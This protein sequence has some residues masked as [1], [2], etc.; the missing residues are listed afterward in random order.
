MTVLR[1]RTIVI[2][3]WRSRESPVA[4]AEIARAGLMRRSMVG[5]VSLL[6]APLARAWPS[7]A[8]RVQANASRDHPLARPAQGWP[9]CAAA[10]ARHPR[11]PARLVALRG[12]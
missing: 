5:T 9:S 3:I 1:S 12:D 10:L 11:Q 2:V 6:P 7:C 4:A 8:N